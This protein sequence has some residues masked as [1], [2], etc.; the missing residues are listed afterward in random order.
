MFDVLIFG[1]GVSGISC[2]LILGSAHKKDF[3]Q[4]KKI[5]VFTHQ[6]ASSL[7][8]AIFIKLVRYILGNWVQNCSLKAHYNLN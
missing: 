5:G 2:A 1:G 4:S 3:A 8:D 7:Q 6:K